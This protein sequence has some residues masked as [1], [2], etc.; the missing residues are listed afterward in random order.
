MEESLKNKIFFFL[1]SLVI[2]IALLVVSLLITYTTTRFYNLKIVINSTPWKKLNCHSTSQFVEQTS[3][4]TSDICNHPNYRSMV[5][6]IVILCFVWILAPILGGKYNSL[7]KTQP[8][9]GFDEN[10]KAAVSDLHKF[11]LWKFR[12][13]ARV[14]IHRRRSFGV[15]QLIWKWID[16]LSLRMWNFSDHSL[17]FPY[18]VELTRNDAKEFHEYLVKKLTFYR[19]IDEDPNSQLEQLYQLDKR[20]Q[21]QKQKQKQENFA[22]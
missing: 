22:D 17:H 21:K 5:V 19:E 4:P 12:H 8:V 7:D 6:S 14:R 2:S 20:E 3:H 15:G 11:K 9:D 10:E 18:S 13:Y 16:L 1:L